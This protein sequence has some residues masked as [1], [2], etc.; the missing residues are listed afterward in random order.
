[1][2]IVANCTGAAMAMARSFSSRAL[3]VPALLLI[4]PA[5]VGI[6]EVR[7]WAVYLAARFTRSAAIRA[8]LHR[9]L[10]SDDADAVAALRRS[11]SSCARPRRS[12]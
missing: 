1:M 9:L 7:E 11:P 8:S 5:L 2:L 10:A 6:R 12:T 3:P 4:E